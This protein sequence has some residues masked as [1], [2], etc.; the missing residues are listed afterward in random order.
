MLLGLS[1]TAAHD[2]GAEELVE[3]AARRGFGALELNEGDGHGITPESDRRAVLALLDRAGSAGVRISGYRALR[4]GHDVALARLSHILGA[5]V[6]LDGPADV[7][8]RVARAEMI[9]A[10]GAEV[11]VVLRGAV[12]A[13]D[14]ALAGSAGL[15]LAWDADPRAGALD[16]GLEPLLLRAGGALRHSRLLGGGPEAALQ[17]GMGVGAMMRRLAV[18]GY[19]GTLVLAPSTARFR[20]AWRKWLG[21]RGGWGCGSGTGED[22]PMAHHAG[23]TSEGANR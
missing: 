23:A 8:A 21:R 2:A 19:A 18:E 14:A 15:A 20:V 22:L 10:A 3:I 12:D 17:D 16:R 7:A 11:A 13:D 1:S 6:L 5:P 9:A 4:T